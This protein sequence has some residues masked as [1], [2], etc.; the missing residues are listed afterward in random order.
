MSLDVYLK[1][2]IDTRGDEVDPSFHEVFTANIT[3]NLAE[4]ARALGC[5][6]AC[7]H[8]ERLSSDPRAHHIKPYLKEALMELAENPKKY[9]KYESENGWGT[10]DGFERFLMGYVI[11][12]L[13][14]P[15]ANVEACV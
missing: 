13:K 12:C 5:Y 11:A 3:H 4:M 7:W 10:T 6:D 1:Y 15:N 14:Y 8:P 9:R 2:P